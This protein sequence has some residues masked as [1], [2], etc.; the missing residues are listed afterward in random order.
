MKIEFI[1]PKILALVEAISLE[2][3]L[4]HNITLN[5]FS[6]EQ[7]HC[8]GYRK[9]LMQFWYLKISIEIASPSITSFYRF[10][11]YRYPSSSFFSDIQFK[12]DSEEGIPESI[13]SKPCQIGLRKKYEEGESCC[14]TCHSCGRFEVSSPVDRVL[15]W[16]F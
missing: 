3:F 10:I 7:C 14:W 16:I 2:H 12:L 6:E 5:S 13:C 15:I 1:I 8:I 11:P 9:I 4:K